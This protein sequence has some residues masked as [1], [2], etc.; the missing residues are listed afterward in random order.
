MS[1]SVLDNPGPHLDRPH[2]TDESSA[3]DGR[4][5]QIS[6]VESEAFCWE[7][8]C[9]VTVGP[10]GR[11]YGHAR[12]VSEKDECPHHCYDGEFSK[13]DGPYWGASNE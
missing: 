6:N 5:P 2:L 3:K 10:S 12:G 8:G 13:M 4:V 7:C 11:E 9:R 1:S